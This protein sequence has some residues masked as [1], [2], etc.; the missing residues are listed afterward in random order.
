MAAANESV[1]SELL[2]TLA[3]ISRFRRRRRTAAAP[4]S[5]R[6]RRR[7]IDCRSPWKQG[8]RPRP[9]KTNERDCGRCERGNDEWTWRGDNSIDFFVHRKQKIC[10]SRLLRLRLNC[11]T[12]GN[13]TR[14]GLCRRVN[15][16]RLAAIT[17]LLSSASSSLFCHARRAKQTWAFGV[18]PMLIAELADDD[19]DNARE[20]KLQLRKGRWGGTAGRRGGRRKEGG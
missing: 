7:P 8:S 10:W 2:R 5:C 17:R 16:L 3:T 9:T 19:D 20:I 14:I 15:V 13:R 4:L 12:I 11:F 18:I 1:T 6:T